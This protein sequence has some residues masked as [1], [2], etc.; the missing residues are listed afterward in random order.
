[1][2]DK[3]RLALGLAL[4][5]FSTAAFFMV[6][7]VEKIVAPELA[8]RVY[9]TFYFTSPSDVALLATGLAQGAVVVAFAVGLFKVWTYGALLIM[10]A[11]ST[12][13]SVSRLIDPFTLP[14]HLFWAG[15]PVLAL[16]IVLFLLRDQ[17]TLFTI[18]L[19][20]S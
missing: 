3:S 12:I 17:D 6:W 18:K 16:L 19:S 13:S 8:R 1:M 15:V 2:S 10:H 4:L 14:N 20:R 7:A 9:E 11:I 5:R